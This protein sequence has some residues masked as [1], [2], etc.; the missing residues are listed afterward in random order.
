MCKSNR[1][2]GGNNF[3]I[4]CKMFFKF[5]TYNKKAQEVYSS[6]SLLTDVNYQKVPKN[7]MNVPFLSYLF[8]PIGVLGKIWMNH[9]A[10]M[11]EN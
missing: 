6:A 3:L 2:W 10:F 9:C 4:Y 5:C 1:R 7:A 8:I 11:M